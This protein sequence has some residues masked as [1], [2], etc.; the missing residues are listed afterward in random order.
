MSMVQEIIV[1]SPEASGIAS[2]NIAN[3][4]NRLREMDYDL[5]SFQIYRDGRK[6][7]GEAASPYTLESPHRLLSAAKGIIG[8]LVLFAIDEGKLSFESHIVDYFEDKLPKDLDERFKRITVYDLMTMQCG[9]ESDAAFIRFL[10]NPEDDL[11][12]GFFR[13]PMDCEPGK[14]FYYNNAVPHLL[15]F[16]VERSTGKDI[17]TY[18]DEKLCRP[19]GI[20]IEAQYNA[21]GVYDP[22]TTVLSAEDFLKLSLWYLQKGR[23]GGR[24][25]IDP[26]L[27]EMACTR[28]VWTGESRPGYHNGKGYCM[29]LWKN[30]FGGCRMDGGGGQIALILPEENMTAVIMG[31]ESRAEQAIQLFYDEIFSKMSGRP[32]E[33][34][35][36]GA[37]MLAKA[38]ADMSRAPYGVTPHGNKESDFSGKTVCFAENKWGIG[39]IRFS[40]GGPETSVHV[41]AGGIWREYQIGLG[42]KWKKSGCPFILPPDTSI[43]NRIYGPDPMECFLSGGWSGNRFVVVCKS[44][45]SMGEY[46][47]VFLFEENGL[48][49]QIPNGISAGMKQDMGMS[50]LES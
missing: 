2:R 9:Q 11:C 37:G 27:V 8:A 29:Q 31:N 6:V 48:K 7:F 28:Q 12:A 46:K 34:D 3:Y 50:Y 47:F 39:Q 1:G 23:W 49:V 25:L 16:L 5:H 35:P 17:K 4:L 14:R 45:A 13:T 21:V 30:A 42:G 20:R 24:W 33:E 19:L 38:A 22:V 15:F 10:E 32:L 40:F 41:Q 43:Q 26:K 44:A 18:M 36:E